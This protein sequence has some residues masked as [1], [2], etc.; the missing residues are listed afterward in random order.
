MKPYKKPKSEKSMNLDIVNSEAHLGVSLTEE[1][2]KKIGCANKGEKSH[3]WGVQLSGKNNPNWKGRKKISKARS[4]EKRRGFG[5][6]SLN[7]KF[8]R[9]DAHHL[10]TH[11]VLYIPKAL[12][13]S[14][15][16]SVI[17]GKDM[18][19]INRLAIEYKYGKREV[20]GKK[21]ER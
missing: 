11:F 4:E 16:H 18:D 19:E 12:H 14:I 2:K 10:D 7:K 13:Q 15:R 5:F 9:S 20:D 3:F 21:Q 6:I 1:T 17:T 8:D